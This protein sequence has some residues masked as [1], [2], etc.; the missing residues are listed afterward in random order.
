MTKAR[1]KF[2]R[3][4]S[5]PGFLSTSQVSTDALNALA[6]RQDGDSERDFEVVADEEEIV[7]DLAWDD[8]SESA[9]YDLEAACQKHGVVRSHIDS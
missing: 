2:E 8:S 9:G 5:V 1:Y 7:A 3:S 6:E 4:S